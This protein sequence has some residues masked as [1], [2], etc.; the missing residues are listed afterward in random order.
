MTVPPEPD[1]SEPA[2]GEPHGPGVMPDTMLSEDESLGPDDFASA[3][4]LAIATQDEAVVGEYQA[5]LLASEA[6]EPDA[7]WADR[8]SALLRVIDGHYASAVVVSSADAARQRRNRTTQGAGMPARI[9]VRASQV[10][11]FIRRWLGRYIERLTT[12]P[13]RAR[14]RLRR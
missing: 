13:V 2:S 3:I 10:W 8:R 6:R 12:L 9:G 1:R 14:T 11:R 4:G 5:W 7:A